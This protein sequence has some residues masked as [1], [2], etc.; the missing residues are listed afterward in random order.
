M[1][2]GALGDEMTDEE[3]QQDIKKYFKANMEEFDLYVGE[4]P[5]EFYWQLNPDQ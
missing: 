3:W 5:L 2:P 4:H 1:E